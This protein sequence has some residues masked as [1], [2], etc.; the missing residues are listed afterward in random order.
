MPF[1]KTADGCK[2]FFLFF[3]DGFELD[4]SK[5]TICLLCPSFADLTVLYAQTV[6]LLNCTEK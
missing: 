2:M 4:R 3:N 5:P 1:V 6:S